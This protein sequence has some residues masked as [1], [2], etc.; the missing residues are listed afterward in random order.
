[1]SS[2]RTA[3]ARSLWWSIVETGG[4]AGLAFV[5]LA[6]LARL[7][8]PTEFGLAALALG[9]VQMLDIATARLFGDAIVQ[10][11]DLERRH[12]ASAFWVTLVLG[13]T[14]SAICWLGGESLASVLDEPRLAAVLGWMSVGLVF[15]GADAIL[16]AQRR[17]E[18]DFR[19][20]A[21]RSLVSRVGAASVGIGAALLG[22]GVWSLVA[23]QLAA[24][25]V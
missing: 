8:T 19:V 11:P 1:M 9:I 10:R 13:A 22:Y 3:A 23:Q 7:L 25:A 5:S 21:L 17:R 16:T 4:L 24:G 18:L 14:F 15:S 6:V 2:V 12:V 20:L